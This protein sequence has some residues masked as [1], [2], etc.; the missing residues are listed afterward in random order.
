MLTSL[1]L[2]TIDFDRRRPA[3]KAIENVNAGSASGSQ[4]YEARQRLVDSGM[5]TEAVRQHKEVFDWM[6]SRPDSRE[7]KD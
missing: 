2:L 3:M 5:T 6:V 1:K 4:Q 7:D